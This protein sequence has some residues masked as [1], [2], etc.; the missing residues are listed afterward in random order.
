MME[1]LRN[2]LLVRALTK[3]CVFCRAGTARRHD[4]CAVGADYQPHREQ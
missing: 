4:T 3:V 1:G 2:F